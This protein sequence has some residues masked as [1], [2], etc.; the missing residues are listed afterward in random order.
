MSGVGITGVVITIAPMAVVISS[1]AGAKVCIFLKFLVAQPLPKFL[2]ISAQSR[3][4][5][6]AVAVLALGLK[7]LFCPR[8]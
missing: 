3:E 4:V 7:V 5:L 1:A 2:V 6:P 8:K